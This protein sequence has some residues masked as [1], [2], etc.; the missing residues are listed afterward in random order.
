VCT[1]L[2]KG[3]KGV[4]TQTQN[5]PQLQEKTVIHHR[6]QYCPEPPAYPLY[7]PLTPAPVIGAANT[8]THSGITEAW[9][10]NHDNT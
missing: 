9:D 6:Q 1:I 4:Y 7:T 3:C 8:I 5:N 10:T 2:A